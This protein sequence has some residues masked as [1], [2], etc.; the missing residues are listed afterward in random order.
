MGVAKIKQGD[1]VIVIAGKDKDKRGKVLRVL[2]RSER[3]VVENVNMV[4]KHQR[5]TQTQ[6]GG[7]VN[8]EAPI[9]ISNVMLYDDTQGAGTRT[10]IGRDRENRKVRVSKKSDT[11]FD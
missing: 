11:V 6:Q 4:R 10:K 1:Q 9:H 5:R 2:P 7:I 3:I 8:K